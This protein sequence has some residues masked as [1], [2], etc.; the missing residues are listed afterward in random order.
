MTQTTTF[1]APNYVGEL[2]LLNQAEAPFYSMIG[3]K[4]ATCKSKDFEWN[5]VDRTRGGSQADV[6]LEGADAP[7]DSFSRGSGSNVAQIVQEGFEV[8]YTKMAATG[9]HDGLNILGDNPVMDEKSFQA[10]MA[11]QKIKEDL[12]WSFLNGVYAK[13]ADNATPRQ[14]RGVLT[15]AT[16]N[17]VT[18]SDA[19]IDSIT[20]EA[21]DE[22]WTKTAHG[23]AVNDEIELTAKTGGTGLTVGNTYFVKTVPSADTFT[24]SASI[25]GATTTISTDATGVSIVKRNALTKPKFDKLLRTMIGNGAPMNGLVIMANSFNKQLLTRLFGYAPEDRNIGGLNINQIETDFA[26][27]G[28]VYNRFVAVDT[29]A[30]IN[31]GVCRPRIVPI[32]G[33]GFL[34]EE[35]LA[36]TGSAEPYQIYGEIGL[37]YGPEEW[38][39]QIVGLTSDEAV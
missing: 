20:I 32:P 29:L 35:P 21:D 13:P 16:T 3:G 17:T 2:H 24:V 19:A 5:E 6:A 31:V 26:K 14:T 39:G 34:F 33:K 28:V 27:L 8:T 11:L 30:V 18:V 1:N 7:A 23:L 10:M 37:E 36:K 15:A 38:H 22:V 12:E 4:A 25:G 9:N